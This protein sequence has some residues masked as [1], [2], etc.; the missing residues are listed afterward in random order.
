SP[1]RWRVPL[2]GS[3]VAPLLCRNFRWPRAHGIGDTEIFATVLP[4]SE[5]EQSAFV[6]FSPKNGPH[7]ASRR[8]AGKPDA[9]SGRRAVQWVSLRGRHRTAER[10]ASA[11]RALSG[12]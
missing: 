5:L 7:R 6:A 3:A 11:R 10:A 8:L 4:T 1:S 2:R 9:R 12:V